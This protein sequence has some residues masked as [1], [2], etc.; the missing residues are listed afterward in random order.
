MGDL[1]SRSKIFLNLVVIKERIVN[2]EQKDIPGR[3]IHLTVI[4]SGMTGLGIRPDRLVNGSPYA[5]RSR[6][7]HFQLGQP[8][9]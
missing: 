3:R 8:A 2:V 4:H 9:R 6:M 1:E 5:D 7:R